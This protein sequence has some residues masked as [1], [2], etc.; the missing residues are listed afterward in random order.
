M[1]GNADEANLTCFLSLLKG[2]QGPAGSKN[3]VQVL[4]GFDIMNLV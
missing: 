3:G 1:P 4:S 2:L